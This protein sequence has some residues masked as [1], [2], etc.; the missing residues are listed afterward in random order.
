MRPPWLCLEKGGRGAGEKL[1]DD[2]A[3]FQ[4]FEMRMREMRNQK[5]LWVKGWNILM[6]SK[7]YLNSEE[8]RRNHKW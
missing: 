4:E 5:K 6:A 1:C 8:K 7:Y 3:Y 2:K